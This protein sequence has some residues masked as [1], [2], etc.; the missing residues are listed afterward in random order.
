MIPQILILNFGFFLCQIENIQHTVRRLER[1]C[2]KI[3]ADLRTVKWQQQQAKK[4]LEEIGYVVKNK[5]PIISNP[6][7][8]KPT[9][10]CR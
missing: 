7:I 3:K 2:K 6:C 5:T 10:P 4:Q 8:L 1:D 9:L